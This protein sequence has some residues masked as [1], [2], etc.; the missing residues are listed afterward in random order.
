M[1]KNSTT[2]EFDSLSYLKARFA[3]ISLRS[4]VQFPLECLNNIFK[5]LPHSL[6]VLD[7][8]S[9]PVIMS[10]ISAAG[11]AS[12][13]VLSD[14][15]D[16]NREELKKWLNDDPA[17]FDWSPHFDHVVLK[18]EGK[19]ENEARARE[20]RLREVVKDVAFCDINADLPLE[21][22]CLGPYDVIIDSC[23]LA[24]TY[25]TR[26]SF[27][28]GINK[29]SAFL[30]RGGTLISYA[31]EQKKDEK[32]GIYYAGTKPFQI[33]PTTANFVEDILQRQGFTDIDVKMCMCSEEDKIKHAYATSLI[34]FRFITAKKV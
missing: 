22:T 30:K 9:G 6:K 18:L 19:D 14:Y 13:I 11:H 29:L 32:M 25:L 20:A 2:Y 15:S 1:A 24:S 34:G 17:A 33:L 8:G 28:N 23:C 5:S 27:E 31:G 10:T 26:D 4:R 7:Y 21:T 12:E 3:D 16:A